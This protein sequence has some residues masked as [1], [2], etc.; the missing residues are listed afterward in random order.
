M[1][2]QKI[3]H[4]KDKFRFLFYFLQYAAAELAALLIRGRE[5]YK[6][7][8]IISERGTDARDNGYHLFRYIRQNHPEINIR[9][10]ISRDSPD[11]EKAASLGETI[12]YRSFRHMLAFVL[13]SVKISTHIMGYAADM[14]FFKLLDIKRPVSGIKV[15]L[16]HG[17]TMHNPDYLKAETTNLDLFVCTARREYEFVNAN[18][19]YADG[20]V[21]KL[22]MCRYDRLSSEGNRTKSRVILFMPTW[23]VYLGGVS[24]KVFKKSNYY[25]AFQ[26]ML[27]DSRIRGLLDKYGYSIEFYPH[28]EIERRIGYF[29][30]PE[31]IKLLDAGSTD[32]QK[33]MIQADILIT[34]F[35]SVAFDFA[36]MK[37]PVIYYQPD[38][39]EFYHGHFQKGYFSY[40][41]DGFGPAVGS[42]EE[43]AAYLEKCMEQNGEMENCYRKRVENFFEYQD[44]NNCERNFQAIL[45]LAKG[46]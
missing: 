24:E 20:V 37:K 15:F 40:E 23:R 36:Y 13:S 10:I 38:R 43:L 3:S 11:Y 25:R 34:D 12:P 32:I 14:Y 8:W 17:I 7:L 26:S 18:F 39:E 27:S 42:L 2:S 21:Q 1:F 35:S 6:N 5:K 9:Y 41:E 45:K 33:K 19:G 28:P 16:Q 4:L 22:G 29:Y 46:K 44:Q 30:V 31:E